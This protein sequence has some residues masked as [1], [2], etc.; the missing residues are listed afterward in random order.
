MTKTE[1]RTEANAPKRPYSK[2][3]LEQVRL[4]AEE[5]VLTVCK[6]SGSVVAGQPGD[7]FKCSFSTEDLRCMDIGT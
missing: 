7:N 4:V 6:T 2:P 1:K 3:Q 5:A